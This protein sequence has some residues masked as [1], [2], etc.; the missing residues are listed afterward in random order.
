MVS[1][2]IED[3]LTLLPPIIRCQFVMTFVEDCCILKA[4]LSVRDTI[5][6]LRRSSQAKQQANKAFPEEAASTASIEICD[7]LVSIEQQKR[8]RPN[9]GTRHKGGSNHT[10]Q[11]VHCPWRSSREQAIGS[12][13]RSCALAFEAS[14]PD[15]CYSAPDEATTYPL[16]LTD[17]ENVSA[18]VMCASERW[19]LLSW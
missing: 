6:P 10:P 17:K 16:C 1:R 8:I 13:R 7:I 12:F 15:A 14:S 2:N 4:S 11:R 5:L 19:R 9:P 18:Y 3:L